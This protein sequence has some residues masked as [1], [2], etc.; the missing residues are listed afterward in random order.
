M[1]SKQVLRKRLGLAIGKIISPKEFSWFFGRY[2][3]V[4]GL[5][6]LKNTKQLTYDEVEG[7]SRYAG[8]DLKYPIPLPLLT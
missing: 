3:E 1:I 2:C 6:A 4:A 8:Y 7:F 5:P